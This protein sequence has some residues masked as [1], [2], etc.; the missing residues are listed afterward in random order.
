[1]KNR[2]ENCWLMQSRMVAAVATTSAQRQAPRKLRTRVTSASCILAWGSSNTIFFEAAA[3][4]LSD[5][6]MSIPVT[7]C[8]RPCSLRSIEPVRHAG[9]GESRAA[10]L[11]PAVEESLFIGGRIALV[12]LRPGGGQHLLALEQC[13]VM[14]FLFRAPVTC[15]L[16][17]L[18]GA[19]VNR[20]H[21]VLGLA[22]GPESSGAGR[23]VLVGVI[24]VDHRLGD[25]IDLILR[26]RGIGDEDRVGVVTELDRLVRRSA[27]A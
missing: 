21:P 18:H 14:D 1:M 3:A 25:G 6:D 15:L 24:T 11:H 2:S 5:T 22:C 17:R 16:Q 9:L 19:G 13:V 23:G 27:G 8:Q 12:V 26:L 4:A 10:R 20:H 7:S